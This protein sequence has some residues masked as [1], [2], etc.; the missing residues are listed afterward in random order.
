MIVP[1]P[2]NKYCLLSSS[3]G[4]VCSG[5]KNIP[6]DEIMETFLDVIFCRLVF[7]LLNAAATIHIW[8]VTC[9]IKLKQKINKCSTDISSLPVENNNRR[10]T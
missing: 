7:S 9:E 10:L 5:I 6:V 3:L 8:C 1:P 4:L 2:K